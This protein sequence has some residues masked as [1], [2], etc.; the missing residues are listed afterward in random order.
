MEGR[1]EVRGRQRRRR[2]Q[3]LDD[4]EKKRRYWKLK[5]EA[6]ELTPWER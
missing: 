2:Q 5:E 1:V 4:I 6:P 3:L